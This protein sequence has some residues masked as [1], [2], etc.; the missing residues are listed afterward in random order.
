MGEEFTENLFQSIDTIVKAR[1]ASLPYDKTIECEVINTDES[2][3][4]KYIVNYQASNF[5]AFSLGPTYKV[6]DLVYVQIPQGDYTQDKFIINKKYEEESSV[7]KKLPFLTF[8][9]NENLSSVTLQNREFYLETN[10][11]QEKVNQDIYTYS[12]FYGENYAAGY[13][14]LGIKIGIKLGINA[15][16]ISGEY[17]VKLIVKGF[18]QSTTYFPIEQNSS[19][20][21]EREFNLLMEDMI[22]P[23]YYNTLGYC[24]QEKVFNIENFVIK[25][26][27]VNIFHD[28]NFIRKDGRA[29]DKFRIYFNNLSVFLGYDSSEFNSSLKRN[30]LYTT[31]G[32]KYD[33]DYYQKPLYIRFAEA[34]NN[35]LD[36]KILTDTLIDSD[37]KIAWETYNPIIKTRG[38]LSNMT[39][40]ESLPAEGI[41]YN[42]NFDD[43]Q[44]R[45]R[46]SFVTII[47]DVFNNKYISNRLDFVKDTYFN[48]TEL[49]D[50]LTSFFRI[51]DNGLIYLNGGA[52][53]NKEG[54]NLANIILNDV[55]LAKNS[56]FHLRDNFSILDKNDNVLFEIND[57]GIIINVP[58]IQ[59]E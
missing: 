18:D 1:L 8:T 57:S 10:G 50:L 46:Y 4:K 19:V 11:I 22:S 13:T 34:I 56:K 37:Y 36:L 38:P 25:S 5:V 2:F 3:D 21:E 27:T 40:F 47:T 44:T 23:N 45:L 31:S 15:D 26:I 16:M 7:V 35:K 12:S 59:K 28:G 58:I 51:D 48:E 6:G 30:F 9:K 54:L 20:L 29:A 14:R 32:F 49:L 41:F 33:N 43:G 24:N 52:N 42:V 39:S 53:T 55:Y 17:G